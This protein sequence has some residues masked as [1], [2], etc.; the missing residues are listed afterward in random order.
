MV[1]T[2]CI[3]KIIKMQVATFYNR[4]QEVA[5]NKEYSKFVEIHIFVYNKILLIFM[6][7]YHFPWITKLKKKNTTKKKKNV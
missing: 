1:K 7:D 3:L 6:D 4:F 2:H 5:T